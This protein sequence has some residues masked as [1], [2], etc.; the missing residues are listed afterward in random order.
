MGLWARVPDTGLSCSSRQPRSSPLRS[1]ECLTERSRLQ[2][3][4]SLQALPAAC[5]RSPRTAAPGPLGPKHP[6]VLATGICKPSSLANNTLP[7]LPERIITEITNSLK[8]SSNHI[9]KISLVMITTHSPGNPGAR[10]TPPAAASP[11]LVPHRR[12]TSLLGGR[13]SEG[14]S[15]PPGHL[16]L[17]GPTGRRW[18]RAV[19]VRQH[20]AGAA[21]QRGR[22]SGV[23][24]S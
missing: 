18:P 24:G 12:G 15:L 19:G 20:Q 4:K 14:G 16:P 21:G 5:R 22:S 7:R 1:T 23:R 17:P 11:V 2:L 13:W 9:K 6:A 8:V 10:P 3:L